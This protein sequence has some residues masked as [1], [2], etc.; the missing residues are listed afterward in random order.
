MQY[1][2]TP[3]WIWTKHSFA[4]KASVAIDINGYWLL[5]VLYNKTNEMHLKDYELQS[6]SGFGQAVAHEFLWT[7]EMGLH[8]MLHVK[9]WLLVLQTDIWDCLPHFDWHISFV[10][11]EHKPQPKH[12]QRQNRCLHPFKSESKERWPYLC[13][14]GYCTNTIIFWLF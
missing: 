4:K 10:R 3:R 12:C 2:S 1:G 13:N 5:A 9:L 6:Y 8:A 14:L 7:V 11:I